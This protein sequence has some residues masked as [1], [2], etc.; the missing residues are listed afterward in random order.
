[1]QAWHVLFAMVVCPV[2]AVLGSWR[3]RALDR[4]VTKRGR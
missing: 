2:F 1:M 4:N 3:L